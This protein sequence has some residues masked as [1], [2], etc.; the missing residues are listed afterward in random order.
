MRIY[1][2]KLLISI[3]AIFF[4]YHLTIGHTIYKFQNKIYS[5]IDK[6]TVGD[7]KEKIREEV[8]NSLKKERILKK[9]DALLLKELFI[10]LNSEI[11]NT[12]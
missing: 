2:Y 7:F 11:K 4:L 8:R 3:I 6:K 1:V 9:E 5:S 10:K 12:K